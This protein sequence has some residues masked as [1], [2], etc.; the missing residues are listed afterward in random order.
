MQHSL[1]PPAHHQQP[2]RLARLHRVL[3]DEVPGEGEIESIDSH[4]GAL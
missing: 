2:R 3:G 4:G 1:Q